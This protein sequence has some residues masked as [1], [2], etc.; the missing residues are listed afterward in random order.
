MFLFRLNANSHV[1]LGHLVRCRQLA[2]ELNKLGHEIGVYGPPYEVMTDVDKTIF[3]IW[4]PEKALPCSKSSR[5]L[6]MPRERLY[7]TSWENDEVEMW[8]PYGPMPLGHVKNWGGQP[9]AV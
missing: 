3:S 9:S 5:H 8:Y 1:G 2:L 7:P 4:E 6:S